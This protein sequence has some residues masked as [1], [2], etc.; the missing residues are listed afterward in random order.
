M[1]EKLVCPR[2]SREFQR[3]PGITDEEVLGMHARAHER[4]DLAKAQLLL[5][6]WVLHQNLVSRKVSDCFDIEEL[7]KD[8]QLLLNQMES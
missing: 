5:R 2:C 7:T 1:S 6:Q 4:Q 8:T 3:Y